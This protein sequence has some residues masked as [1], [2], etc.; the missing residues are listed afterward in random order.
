MVDS[1]VA[2]SA[3]GVVNLPIIYEDNSG[4][5]VAGIYCQVDGADDYINVPVSGA[6]SVGTL[7]LSAGIPANMLDGSFC[8]SI[9]V[10]DSQGMVSSHFHTC[11]S[12]SQPM[13]CGVQRESGGEGVTSTLHDMGNQGGI[14]IIN[15]ETFTVPDRIDVFYGGEWVTGTGSDPGPL[16]MVPPLADCSNP[17][18]GYVGAN[19]TFCFPFSPDERGSLVEVV[20]SG[21]VRGGTAWNYTITCAG[22]SECDPQLKII[23]NT[24]TIDGSPVN[25]DITDVSAYAGSAGTCY[26]IQYW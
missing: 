18:E 22:S 5:D 7:L 21:C 6:G 25:W 9:S 11:V 8:I 10:Y 2:Y 13:S 15:Y 1:T 14:V 23:E 19:G 3:G 20:V 26:R 24:V 17:T 16:G 4:D 12:V